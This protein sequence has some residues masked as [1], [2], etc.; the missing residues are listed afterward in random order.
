MVRRRANPGRPAL[1]NLPVEY[2]HTRRQLRGIAE[3]LIAGPQHRSAGT[4]R[5]AVRPDGFAGVAVALAVRGTRFTWPAGSAEVAGPVGELA[6]AAGVAFGPPAGVY[7]LTD[8]LPPDTVLDINPAAADLVYRS[9]YAGGYALKHLLPAEHPVLWPEHF[10]VAV[11]ADEVTYGVSPG[12]DYQPGPYAYIAP[13]TARTGAS[14]NAPFGAAM[15]LDPQHD[16]NALAAAAEDFFS[17]GRA[18]P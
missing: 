18:L 10:D 5:L 13:W 16:V 15:P 1:V 14:W 17:R 11:S 4:I 9:L 6:D 12:D 7:A 2:V 3:S 8:P